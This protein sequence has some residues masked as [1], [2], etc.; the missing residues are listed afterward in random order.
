M[1]ANKF[2]FA[3]LNHSRVAFAGKENHS[4]VSISRDK[5]LFKFSRRKTFE[6]DQS[7]N[8]DSKCFNS[9]LVT[10]Q[11]IKSKIK[12]TENECSNILSQSDV[13]VKRCATFMKEKTPSRN[14]DDSGMESLNK[15]I[16]PVPVLSNAIKDDPTE[17]FVHFINFFT[18]LLRLVFKFA[19]KKCTQLCHFLNAKI[20]SLVNQVFKENG[21]WNFNAK[22]T[23]LVAPLALLLV[24]N[25]CLCF[26]LLVTKILLFKIPVFKF[27]KKSSKEVV[28]AP[29]VSAN[30]S[31][32]KFPSASQSFSKS[33]SMKSE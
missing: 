6:M 9:M 4:I 19:E 31:F 33:P 12:A 14:F 32:T 7:L 18:F 1:F 3:F 15:S 29:S 22:H 28:K 10:Y 8:K 21:E 13:E 26:V 17:V 24:V 27:L 25:A 23:I 20:E 30:R 2:C 16:E 5:T 11:E